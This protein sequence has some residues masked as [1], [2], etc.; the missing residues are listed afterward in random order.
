VPDAPSDTSAP[1]WSA[2]F[3]QNAQ[4]HRLVARPC[5]PMVSKRRGGVPRPLTAREEP[6]PQGPEVAPTCTWSRE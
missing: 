1:G 6:Q 2:L 3:H 5:R 4:H